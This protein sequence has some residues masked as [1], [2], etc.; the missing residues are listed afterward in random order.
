MLGSV[1]EDDPPSPV[2]SPEASLAPISVRSDDDGLSHR[3]KSSY[4]TPASVS[5]TQGNRDS[6]M[7]RLAPE[8]KPWLLPEKLLT[9]LSGDTTPH[10][11]YTFALRPS[12]TGLIPARRTF[13][14]R[15]SFTSMLF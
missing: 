2:P 3:N 11:K 5:T 7:S 9:S 4:G 15:R 14:L 8:K 13:A 10:K 12:Y 1:D 6:E